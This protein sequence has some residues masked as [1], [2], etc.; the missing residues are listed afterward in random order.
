[1]LTPGSVV[2][3]LGNTVDHVVTV[4]DVTACVGPASISEPAA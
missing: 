4:Y 2:T 3:A 1:M